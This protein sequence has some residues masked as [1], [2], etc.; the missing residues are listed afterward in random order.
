MLLQKYER[1]GRYVKEDEIE[2]WQEIHPTMMSDEEDVGGKF[3]VHRQE[4]RSTEFNE[5]METLDARAN[6]S[7]AKSCPRIERIHGTPCKKMPPT[8]TCDWMLSSIG[9]EDSRI[10]APQSPDI[11]ENTTE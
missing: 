5:F 11:F 3:K 2:K 4:W 7:S 8:V 6:S 10:L 9:R 1:R